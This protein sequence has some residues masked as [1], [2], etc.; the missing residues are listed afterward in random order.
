V[1]GLTVAR[2][3]PDAPS[4]LSGVLDAAM[5]PTTDLMKVS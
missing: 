3:N 4:E 1:K 2:Y 5:L